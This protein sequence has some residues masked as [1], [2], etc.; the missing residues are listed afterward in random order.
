MT[1]RSRSVLAGSFGMAVEEPEEDPVAV[2]PAA[3]VASDEGVEVAA[4]GSALAAEG[5]DRDL[6][7]LLD[8]P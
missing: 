6:L 4:A 2:P 8:R 1:Y 5:P 3:V 7:D